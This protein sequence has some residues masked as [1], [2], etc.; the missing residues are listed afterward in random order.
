M[1]ELPEVE[2]A[3]LG[4]TPHILGKTIDRVVA[5]AANLRWPISPELITVLPGQIIQSV[6]RRGK[7]LL[8]HSHVGGVLIHLG[9]TG[10]LRVVSIAN[11]PEKHDHFDIVFED[12][13]VLRLNDVRRFGSVTWAGINPNTHKLLA[14]L[15]PEPLTREFHATYLYQKSRGRKITIKQFLMDHKV[16]AGVGNIYANE[17]LFHARISPTTPAGLVSKVRC[18]ELVAIIKSVLTTSIK[19]GGTMLDIRDGTEK[20]GYFHQELAVYRRDGQPC[21]VCST[22]IQQV[23]VGQRSNYYCKTC[24]R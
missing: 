3:R 19:I 9:M 10:Y 13:I 24:Q 1:P 21:V 11:V 20:I 14:E 22:P 5:H 12:G 7:Y 16:V 8:L 23:R 17:V 18:K 4:I 15:G 6:E 2:V